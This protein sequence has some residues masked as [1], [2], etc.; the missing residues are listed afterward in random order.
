ML[1]TLVNVGA[2]IIGGL[3]GFLFGK[4]FPKRM[5]HTVTQG[6]GLAVLLIGGKMALLTEN[7]LIVIGS[8]VLGGI[9]GELIDIELRLKNLGKWL[10]KRITI[11]KGNGQFSKAFVTSSLIYCI[12]AMAI[13]GALESGLHGNNSIL[14]AKAMLDGISSVVFTST[15]GIGVIFSALPVLI[16]QGG[17]SLLAGLL[18]GLSPAVINEMSA[19]GGLL[20]VAIGI[21]ILEIKEIKV[22]NLLPGIFVAVPLYFLANAVQFVS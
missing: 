12:G 17:I 7:A 19:T 5:R 20:I 22:A 8:L 10:E 9:V 1:G 16:Y 15:L 14:Y 3:I 21:N 11:G 4:A 13:M 6:I 2:I 18:Q